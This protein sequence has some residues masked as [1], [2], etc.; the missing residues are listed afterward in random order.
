[1]DLPLD[2]LL[3]TNFF[4][5]YCECYFLNVIFWV[6]FCWQLEIWLNF[7]WWPC[8]Q[9]LNSVI[10]LHVLFLIFEFSLFKNIP[11]ANNNYLIFSSIFISYICLFYFLITL[12][13]LPSVID[14]SVDIGW[15]SCPFLD[16]TENAFNNLPVTIMCA[17]LF[18]ICKYSSSDKRRPF[19]SWLAMTFY[20]EWIL[21]FVKFPSAF[22]KNHVFL[23]CVCVNVANC[24]DFFSYA[25]PSLHSWNNKHPY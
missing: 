15:Y 25:K 3:E 23:F 20:H 6:T 9:H 10:H 17:G 14:G 18:L 12:T 1:M 24:I 21:P 22:L 19:Y 4:L 7:A 5:W 8:T 13:S 2:L 11:I 16:F